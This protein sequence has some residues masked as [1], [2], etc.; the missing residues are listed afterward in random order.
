MKIC[1]FGASSAHID[2]SYIAKV[3]KLGEKMA[4]R[5]HSLV[6]GAGGSGL[7]GAA[8]RGVKRRG[9]YVHGVVPSFFKEDGVE[10]L[11]E[12]CDRT[13]YTNTMRER[14]AIMEED[15]DAFIIVPGGVGTLEE[16]FEIVTL[17]QLNRLHKAIA[18]LNE[19]GYYDELQVFMNTA[20]DRK[21][22][23]SACLNL[24]RVFDDIDD[25][26]DYIEQYVPVSF[27]IKSTKIGE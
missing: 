17:K 6:F 10:L 18:V 4:E 7:M 16:F 1:V 26:L 8:A 20:L 19:Q 14:K 24:Y 15:A 9:G 25:M 12:E 13:T 2:D 21:F 22:I 3:E 11:F 27:S 5:G 23:T